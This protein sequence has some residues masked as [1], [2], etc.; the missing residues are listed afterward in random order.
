MLLAASAAG[1][2]AAG[3]VFGALPWRRPHARLVLV[4]PAGSA[5]AVGLTAWAADGFAPLFAALFLV[6]V[7]AGPAAIASSALLDT[8][9]PRPALARAYTLMVAVGLLWGAAGNAAG[10][11]VAEQFGHR[12]AL[13]LSAC[14]LAVLLAGAVVFRRALGAGPAGQGS[15][16][17]AAN[18]VRP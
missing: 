16:R 8:L 15:G 11:V 18:R 1:E 14:W 6:G 7:C 12:A 9:V 3:L 2:V 13:A 10:G 5:T 17:R 4:A